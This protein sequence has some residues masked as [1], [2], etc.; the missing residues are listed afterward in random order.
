MGWHD[1]SLTPRTHALA[2]IENANEALQQV[3][4]LAK[5]GRVQSREGQWLNLQ[6]DTV[7]LHGDS[8]N[9]VAFARLLREELKKQKI[10]VRAF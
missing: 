6:A 10:E 2:H 9:A 8:P 7:C 3:L 1:G 4:S 5:E